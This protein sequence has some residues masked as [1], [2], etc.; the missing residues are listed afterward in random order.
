MQKQPPEVFSK[1]KQ[2]FKFRKACNGRGEVGANA[3]LLFS[4]IINAVT[5][6]L[7]AKVAHRKYF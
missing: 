5:I 1:K 6:K 7:S 2:S 3:P 4:K